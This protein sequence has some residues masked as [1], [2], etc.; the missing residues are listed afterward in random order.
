MAAK[1]NEL[2][3]V[4]TRNWSLDKFT[5]SVTKNARRQGVK[6]ISPARVKAGYDR[7]ETVRSTV[8][9]LAGSA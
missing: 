6:K 9:A 3:K 4:A 5:K 2:K 8:K 1:K 7:G